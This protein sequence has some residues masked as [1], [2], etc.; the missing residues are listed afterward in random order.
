MS[1]YR[2][3]EDFSVGEVIDLGTYPVTREEVVDFAREFDPQPFHVDEAAA[4]ASFFG[5]LVASGWHTAAMF[6]R[7][8]YDTVVSKCASQGAPGVQDLKWLRP[9]RPGDRLH[10]IAQ[11]T[12]ARQSRSRPDIGLVS[13]DFDVTNQDGASV[14]TLRS[15]AMIRRRE[16]EA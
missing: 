7:M 8:Y 2:H 1:N 5:G 14:M 12:A 9:V 6:M 16:A 4:A 13:F 3:F 15:T 10:G 11:V